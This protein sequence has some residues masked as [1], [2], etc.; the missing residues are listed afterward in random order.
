MNRQL[1]TEQVASLGRFD[2]IDV[3]DDVSNR[4]VRSRELFDKPRVAID[5][6]YRERV[7]MSFKLLRDRKVR[8]A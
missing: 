4:Y 2:R 8:S 3:A 6:R 5:P 1:I 7:A